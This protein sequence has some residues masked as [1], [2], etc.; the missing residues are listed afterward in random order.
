MFDVEPVTL[1]MSCLL[2]CAFSVPFIYNGQKNKKIEKKLLINLKELASQK[3]ANPTEVETWRFRYAMG[4]DQQENILVYLRQDSESLS[5]SLNLAEYKNVQLIKKYQESNGKE[6]N[7]KL[8][9]YVGLQ[10][11]PKNASQEPV[12]LEIFD[13]EMYS[14]LNGETVLADKWVAIINKQVN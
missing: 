10:L 12:T 4:L 3:G 7:H 13:A 2:M 5:Y 9:E 8:P 1:I 6:L 14:D 11:N